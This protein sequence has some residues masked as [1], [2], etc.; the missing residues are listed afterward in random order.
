M[1]SILCFA[2][3]GEKLFPIYKV[4]FSEDLQHLYSL[5]VER[6]NFVYF[7]VGKNINYRSLTKLEVCCPVNVIILEA[8][9]LLNQSCSM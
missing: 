1:L 4:L 6:V 8:S 9:I 3:F 2:V 7:F 5:D